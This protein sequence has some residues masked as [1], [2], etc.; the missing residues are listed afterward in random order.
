MYLIFVD[1]PSA[2]QTVSMQN[3]SALVA[4]PGKLEYPKNSC[5]LEQLC[6]LQSVLRN[7]WGTH[8]S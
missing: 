7:T 2:W 4:L 8:A 1:Q 6:R 5:I 3:I